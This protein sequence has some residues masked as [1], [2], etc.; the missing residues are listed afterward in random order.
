MTS[1]LLEK[2]PQLTDEQATPKWSTKMI[3]VKSIELQ[4]IAT[5]LSYHTSTRYKLQHLPVSVFGD[6]VLTD[7]PSNKLLLLLLAAILEAKYSCRLS[8][9]VTWMASDKNGSA[10]SS[11]SE[12]VADAAC[13]SISIVTITIVLTISLSWP[14]PY[15]YY[16]TT[17]IWI[18]LNRLTT[19]Q[20]DNWC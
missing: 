4:H 14:S 9:L 11:L 15:S 12:L 6:G 2:R 19:L 18:T 16:N 7:I 20:A 13:T 17:L 1:K 5:W 8:V 10:L 3:T